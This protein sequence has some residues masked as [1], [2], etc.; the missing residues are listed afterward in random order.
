MK[1]I[2]LLLL[3]MYFTVVCIAQ[4]SNITL[5]EKNKPLSAILQAIKAQSTVDFYYSSDMIDIN[6]KISIHVINV[7]INDALK[8]IFS[9]TSIAFTING[10][11]VMLYKNPHY[12]ITIS[13]YLRE[14][15]T[16]EL[17]IG[18]T[19]ST[20]PTYAGC[21]TNAYGFYSLTLPVDTFLLQY[22]Y[23]GFQ[24]VDKK[25]ITQESQQIDVNLTPNTSLT[26]AQVIADN[27]KAEPTLNKTIV[28]LQEIN[29]I[30]MVLGE[31][32]VVKYIML[33]PG[34][35][36][37]SEG[38]GYMYVRGGGPDQN[39]VLIDDAVIYNAYH[40]LGLSSLFSGNELRKAELHK[41]G[42]SSKYGGRL[43]SVLDMSM[44]DGNRERY[45]VD[46]MVGVIS[47]RVLV[48]GPIQKSKSSF[49]F[50]M[51]KSYINQVAKVVTNNDDD[52]LDYNYYDIHAK[53]STNIG[54]HDRLML[55]G[56]MGNDGLA[57][58][59]VSGLSINED[60][61][62]WG[63]KAVS[64]RWNHQFNGRLFA[65]TSMVSSYYKT[66]IAFGDVDQN[67]GDRFFS[68][69][70]SS[71]N[72]Y[73]LK[74]DV[75]FLMNKKHQFKYGAGYTLHYFN[76]YTELTLPQSSLS[77]NTNKYVSP[78]SFAYA[79]W[80]YFFNKHWEFTSGLR[81]SYFKQVKSYTG[82]EPRL[83]IK[84]QGSKNW[85]FNAS[86][87][88]MNQ[89][90]HLI[91]AFNGLGLPSDAWVS[92]NDKLAPQSSNLVTVG[93]LK[94]N[95]CNGKLAVS[96][97]LYGKKISNTTALKE[98]ASFFQ[99]L[100]LNYAVSSVSSW[101]DLATQG[102]SKSYGAELMVKKFGNRIDGHFSYTLSKT[103]MLFNE[104]NNGNRFLA[105]FDRTHDI[106]LYIGYK[107]GKHFK[108]AAN[109][110]YGT[111][112]LISLPTGKFY[113]EEP[114]SGGYLVENYYYEKKNNYRIQD[115][116]RMD[117]SIQYIGKFKNRFENTIELSLYNVYNRAN[118]F[119]YELS[120]T[121]DST[122]SATVQ[123]LQK[124][125]LFPIM[126]SLSWGVKF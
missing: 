7:T 30:P 121:P 64:L 57:N 91:S 22:N 70:Q 15:G 100:P 97:E 29:N 46:A 106:G 11:K 81:F 37:G 34:V 112:N 12:R 125:S 44:K 67:S 111:G 75:D 117:L 50:S 38:N 53:L 85:Q 72:D 122:G 49:L 126:P 79:E 84:Y 99:V 107:A 23:V 102:S 94:N 48:E 40:F 78:E 76:S 52:I 33:S 58:N 39:L 104:L 16:G 26:E 82:I 5:K 3:I 32:D 71:I 66:R 28:P 109:W 124:V 68:A 17:L 9:N 14:Q 21:M 96:V 51:R 87:A 2:G 56:Y 4:Q 116:H 63:N 103:T 80:Q 27:Q 113:A 65:N 59:T 43:S 69:V 24:R 77:T 119:Y 110:V 92:S 62:S 10:D 45:G 47:S 86:Y 20:M 98:G 31:K 1:K 123:R 8:R 118:P 13:G 41:G 115:Y 93:V 73:T 18:A 6:Q 114:L 83:N 101:E 55:S 42:F 25:I 36:K 35:Q 19:V 88:L 61:I 90:L 105:S 54:T 95:L 60:G 108:F 89:Y 74:T 120:T